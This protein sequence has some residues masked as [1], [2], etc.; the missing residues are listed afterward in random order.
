MCR[1]TNK[2]LVCTRKDT[3]CN[4][5][6]VTCLEYFVS[7]CIRKSITSSSRASNLFSKCPLNPGEFRASL[8]NIRVKQKN[9][10]CSHCT[11]STLSLARFCN[12]LVE[13]TTKLFL[14]VH[15]ERIYSETVVGTVFLVEV[16]HHLEEG[17]KLTCFS[18]Q[19]NG[20]FLHHCDCNG[21]LQNVKFSDGACSESAT[22]E[23]SEANRLANLCI[24]ILW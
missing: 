22:T 11:E 13:R 7:L 20:T 6:N 24:L 19:W 16:N 9:S 15:F 21:S 2:S 18:Q 10:A 8:K 12:I 5:A 1:G 17:I 3:H 14:R 4:Q 23:I